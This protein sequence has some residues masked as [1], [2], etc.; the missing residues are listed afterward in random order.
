ML[1]L[2]FIVCSFLWL[3]SMGVL[4]ECT[5]AYFVFQF[6]VIMN[7]VAINSCI[8]GCT[9]AYICIP[10]LNKCQGVRLLVCKYRFNFIN[11]SQTVFQSGCYYFPFHPSHYEASQFTFLPAHGIFRLLNFSH[12]SRYVAVARGLI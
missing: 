1:L 10:L 5:V 7:K 6:W 11:S 9:W 4:Y 8:Q 2:V 12:S 3:S